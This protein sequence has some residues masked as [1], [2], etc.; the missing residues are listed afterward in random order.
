MRIKAILS[1][2]RVELAMVRV[3]VDVEGPLCK[4]EIFKMVPE[5]K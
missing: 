2:H 3:A 5:T 4:E 1:V